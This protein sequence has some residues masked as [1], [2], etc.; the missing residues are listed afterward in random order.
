MRKEMSFS[1]N[2]ILYI[3]LLDLLK[4][5]SIY[6]MSIINELKLSEEFVLR[7]TLSIRPLGEC[8]IV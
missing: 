1:G 7:S 5:G 4:S 2:L 3:L 6:Q 8:G